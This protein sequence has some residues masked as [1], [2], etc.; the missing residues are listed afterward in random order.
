DGLWGIRYACGLGCL[1]KV[2]VSTIKGDAVR[3]YH[4]R[5]ARA[6]Q[7]PGWCPTL[8]RQQARAQ[9]RLA[10]AQQRQRRTFQQVAADYRIYTQT[11]KASYR[12]DLSRLRILTEA[13]G[14]LYLE[15]ITPQV[16]EQLRTRLIEQGCARSTTNRY[17]ALIS[18]IFR[19][20]IRDGH[21]TVNPAAQVPRFQT[22]A[23]P[24][25]LFP[26]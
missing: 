10:E 7:D 5:K 26:D 1:H 3:T 17:K 4:E 6:H 24:P 12:T 8:E 16:I 19:R 11:H 18:A 20:A 21:A 14:E 2:T 25:V 23:A 9:A 22:P 13:I 15:D